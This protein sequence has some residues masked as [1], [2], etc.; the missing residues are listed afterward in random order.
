MFQLKFKSIRLV[1]TVPVLVRVASLAFIFQADITA[2][3]QERRPVLTLSFDGA[4]LS[5]F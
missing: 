2:F 1:M 3:A 5:P 4:E